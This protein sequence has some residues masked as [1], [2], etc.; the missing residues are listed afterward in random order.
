MQVRKAAFEHLGSFIASFYVP[1]DSP[2]SFP[3]ED[4]SSINPFGDSVLMDNS[5]LSGTLEEDGVWVGPPEP[6]ENK[7]QSG[8][9]TGMGD[10]DKSGARTSM[11]D[12]KETKEKEPFFYFMSTPS[13]VENVALVEKKGAGEEEEEE[14]KEVRDER[15]NGD[16]KEEEGDEEDTRENTQVL[17]LRVNKDKSDTVPVSSGAETTSASDSVHPVSLTTE[18]LVLNVREEALNEGENPGNH[19]EVLN[20]G[21]APSNNEKAPNEGEIPSNHEETPNAGE[22]PSNREE[23]PNAG[24]TTSNREQASSEGE[25]PG[26]EETTNEKEDD[27]NHEEV[28]NEREP[29]GNK[30][31]APSEGE[32]CGTNHEEAQTLE[33][34]DAEKEDSST[35]IGNTVLLAAENQG[36]SCGVLSAATEGT[37]EE[38][39]R[40]MLEQ[41][42][43]ETENDTQKSVGN[44]T[45]NGE[46]RENTGEDVTAASDS[47][48]P[49]TQTRTPVT[50]EEQTT[51]VS[52]KAGQEVEGK[53]EGKEG[54]EK[55]EGEV[56][57]SVEG[58]TCDGGRCSGDSG[59][60]CATG[61]ISEDRTNR[62]KLEGGVDTGSTLGR[63]EP[64]KEEGGRPSQPTARNFPPVSHSNYNDKGHSE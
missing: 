44:S 39:E 14:E 42:V 64:S 1:S 62:D 25:N 36:E 61:E 56:V 59:E 30:K 12:Q 7:E 43:D 28:P 5:L 29:P 4:E 2:E 57:K 10:Q 23:T 63:E 52:D 16:K 51:E 38:R 54:E 48:D 8:S 33:G 34:T 60:C 3:C 53:E 11:G 37:E 40:E 47:S 6:V 46:N 58:E 27:S 41:R 35:V 19:E 17:V 49:A 26:R 50:H 45:E 18:K 31:E 22:T 21:D 15:E 13:D 20:E 24:E 55:E 9:G 32:S